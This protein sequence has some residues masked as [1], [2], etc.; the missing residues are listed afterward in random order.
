MCNLLHFKSKLPNTG[1]RNT[2]ASRASPCPFIQFYLHDLSEFFSNSFSI[3]C[4][5]RPATQGQLCADNLGGEQLCALQTVIHSS[6]LLT[7]LY[8]SL[9]LPQCVT[10]VPVYS[11][12]ISSLCVKCAHLR[13]HHGSV[14]YFALLL[15][16]RLRL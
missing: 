13:H 8:E 7:Y 11:P 4:A 10:T 15:L 5:R 1:G 16:L 6:S 9:G 3:E 14:S 12:N 2:A